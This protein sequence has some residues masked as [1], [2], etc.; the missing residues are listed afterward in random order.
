[1][2]DKARE[3]SVGTY[4]NKF[5]APVFQRM[6]RAEAAALP[7]GDTPAIRNGQ[8][9][10]IYRTVGQC[11]C[12]TCGRVGPWSEGLGGMHTGH[13]LGSRANSILFEEFNVACQCS[14]DNRYESGAP[15]RFR[16]WMLAVRGQAVVQRLERLRNEVVSFSKEELVDK[17]I[18]YQDRLKAAEELI[19]HGLP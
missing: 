1:M 19:N 9:V 10:Q 8:L 17:R 6:V 2:L 14:R 15:Q 5:V 16:M 3:Y 13:F 4:K 11:V 18:G 7:D 12:V